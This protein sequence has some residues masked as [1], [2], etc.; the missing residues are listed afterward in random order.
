M[1]EMKE[2]LRKGFTEL[3]TPEPDRARRE[4][5]LQRAAE[6]FGRMQKNPQ[7]F[8]FWRRLTAKLTGLLTPTGGKNMQITT[9]LIGACAVAMLTVVIGTSIYQSHRT[10]GL[11]IRPGQEPVQTSIPLQPPQP[12]VQ[13]QTVAIAPVAQPK[14]AATSARRQAE[15]RLAGER[16]AQVTA[17]GAL[18][19][20]TPAQP[21]ATG[22]AEPWAV[23]DSASVMERAK[24][25]A[26]VV[27]REKKEMAYN[28]PASQAVPA[29]KALPAPAAGG[30][31]DFETREMLM[32]RQAMPMVVAE[33][34]IPTYQDVGRD[35]FEKFSSS[36]LHQV[37]VEPVSTFSADVDTASYG[38]VRRQLNSGLLPQKNAVRVEEMINYFDYDYPAPT[39]AGQPFKPTVAVYPTPWN[40]R[41]KLLH[42]GVK[43]YA[44]PA[45][46]KPA[47]NLV[48]LIDVSGSMESP[49]K[50]PLAKNALRMLVDSLQ[51][52]DT[53][54]LAVYAGAAGVVLEPTPVKEKGKIL[55][56][57]DQLSAG[58]STA[59]GEG[60][61][62]AYSLAAR[63]LRKNGVNRVM[64]FTDGDFNVGIT[65][66]EELKS[67]IEK[68][69]DSGICLSLFGF[70]QGN[71]NDAVMQALAQN[72]NGIA[73]Y[74]DTLNEAR[75]LLV[76]EASSTLFTIANDLKFQVEFNPARVKE[77]RLI[78]Y[79]TRALNRADFNNDKIDAGEIGA[80]TQV[81]AIYEV[82]AP[83]SEAL[84]NDPL[85]YG[86]APAEATAGELGFLRLRWKAPGEDASTLVETPIT[87][88]EPASTE[89]RFAAAIAGFGQ[90]LRGSVYLGDWG[91]DQAI[92][93]ALAN[94]GED[95]FGYRIEA[96]NLMRLAQGL[97]N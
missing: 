65:N 21:P 33:A 81:T 73:A 10:P 69:R 39:S 18:Q 28:G 86:T 20:A 50:L 32:S 63:N 74:I 55:A 90:L 4:L 38:F 54:G 87:G 92:G 24:Q 67:F 79:E 76:D 11:S 62:L 44:L 14:T 25:A 52:D 6:E 13:G 85:R 34:P 56:A 27:A 53:V 19:S 51:P 48:F 9:K 75:K 29:L 16:T 15:E 83:G 36:T 84:L 12:A 66:Q 17:K 41:T 37:A 7:G 91:W 77:Y 78:G 68:Q 43:G 23:T 47:S 3:P 40:S 35:N 42:I 57:I 49:D 96:V 26:P 31:R 89:T 93:L 71:Y 22:A 8:S 59:G 2:R 30:A 61:K 82:T 64:L 58:G 95:A 88:A 46:H 97:S 45:T 60:L 94:R 5:N 72:G 70:G 80:G 1:D